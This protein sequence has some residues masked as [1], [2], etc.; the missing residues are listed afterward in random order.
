L[1]QFRP[2]HPEPQATQ[3]YA[4]ILGR[5]ERLPA[6]QHWQDQSDRSRITS[7]VREEMKFHNSPTL[8]KGNIHTIRNSALFRF[9]NTSLFAP[10][11]SV[12]RLISKVYSPF[13]A[14]Q[15]VS[16]KQTAIRRSR[17]IVDVRQPSCIV[18]M[19]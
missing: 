18:V 1:A 17:K 8:P 13:A 14:A 6:S 4:E 10:P 11:D 19:V 5:Y 3:E 16:G 9:R 12:L 2:L 7:T 15:L